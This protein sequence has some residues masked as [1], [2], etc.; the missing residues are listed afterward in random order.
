MPPAPYSC[1]FMLPRIISEYMEPNRPNECGRMCTHDN[2]IT[3]HN[4]IVSGVFHHVPVHC[5]ECSG[6][7]CDER[8]PWLRNKIQK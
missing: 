5:I 8:L 2:L 3:F 1:R 7:L 6:K 4:V